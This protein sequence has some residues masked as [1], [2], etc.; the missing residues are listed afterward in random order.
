M[1]SH[2]D[3]KRREY[4]RQLRADGASLAEICDLVKCSQGSASVW[5]RGVPLSPEQRKRLASK[6]PK[7][8]NHP[9][10]RD[11]LERDR[12]T[13]EAADQ[14]WPQ[15]RADPDM[16]LGLGIWMGEGDKGRHALGLTN[17]DPGIVRRALGF[18]AKLGVPFGRLRC[19]VQVHRSDQVE[20]AEKFWH[21]VTGLDRSQFTKTTVVK[22]RASR[23]KFTRRLPYGTFY[24][25][26]G[27]TE[28]Q[29]KVLRWIEL[30]CAEHIPVIDGD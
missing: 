1:R 16:M 20:T 15:V 2:R 10:R 12:R 7:G 23:G 11:R 4:A 5:C 6:T 8:Q 24:V 3:S 21:T 25:C 14:Q 17:S 19:R 29:T 18:F 30:C 26:Y 13:R 9:A 27:S 22:S 28:L